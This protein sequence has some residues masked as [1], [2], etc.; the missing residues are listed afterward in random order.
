MFFRSIIYKIHIPHLL[1]RVPRKQAIGAGLVA[2]PDGPVHLK[3][4]SHPVQ[5]A[6]QAVT[7]PHHVLHIVNPVPEKHPQNLQKLVQLTR[8]AP[9]REDLHQVPEV[10]RAVKRDPAHRLVADEPGRH[11][12]LGEPGRVNPFFPVP[13]EVDPLSHQQRDRVRS[14]RVTRHVEVLEVELPDEP[15]AGS[16]V[17]KVTGGVGESK[18]DLDEVQNVDV[19]LQNAVV[20]GGLERTVIIR[21]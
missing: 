5:T 16:E 10:V 14:V 7:K 18:T 6:I 11:H 19:R 21:L 12:Q 2:L 9:A 3:G 8:Q 13:L 15:V 1:K 17:G 20:I 4:P